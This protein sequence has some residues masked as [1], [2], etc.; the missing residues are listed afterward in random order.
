MISNKQQQKLSFLTNYYPTIVLQLFLFFQL[1]LAFL[2]L[3]LLFLRVFF[4]VKVLI[5]CLLPILAIFLFLMVYLIRFILDYLSFKLFHIS[6][7]A[8]LKL[9]NFVFF[10]LLQLSNHCH[11]IFRHVMNTGRIG[12]SPDQFLLHHDQLQHVAQVVLHILG[13]HIVSHHE[14][15]EIISNCLYKLRL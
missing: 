13:L 7:D 11:R 1:L 15:E 5:A 14:L 6:I 4:L 12:V 9:I 3:H 10:A 8:H 2:G